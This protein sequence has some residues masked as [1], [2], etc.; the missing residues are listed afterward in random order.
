MA[1]DWV[2]AAALYALLAGAEAVIL[3]KPAPLVVPLA[4]PVAALTAHGPDAVKLTGNDAEEDALTVNPLP[5]CTPG[6]GPKVMVCDC[7]VEP[8]GRMVNVPDAELAA[9]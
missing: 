8:W 2:T 7:N 5:Y 9:L 3:H 4:V 1:N 6:N